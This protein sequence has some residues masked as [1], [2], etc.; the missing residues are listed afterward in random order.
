M[1]GARFI[2]RFDDVCPGMNWETFGRFLAFFN[3][4][5]AIRPVVGVVPDNRDPSL[6]VG[7][8]S[9][10]F[11]D[12]VR[13]W[14]HH[15]WTIAQ[16]GHTHQYTRDDG[17]V[18]GIGRKSEFAG[19]PYEE[20]RRKLALGKEILKREG[21][22]EPYFMAPSHSF[23]QAT[24]R[25]LGALGFEGITDGYGVYP[26][27]IAGLKA[28]PQLFGSPI[29]FGFGIY[30]IC[31]HCNR[32]PERQII[33]LLNFMKRN[34]GRIIDFP[35]ALDVSSPLVLGGMTRVVTSLATKSIRAARRTIT[36]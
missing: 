13:E 19:L 7:P 15:R 12:R 27:R 26:Y 25:A 35:S 24:L 2:I 31:I 4:H 5:P 1:M 22:W 14:R 28:V 11:W 10:G 36:Q 29:N 6:D 18:L 20:Q 8:R 16:H 3:D 32:M 23:D 33:S 21:V 30:T 9:S 34:E 17:G